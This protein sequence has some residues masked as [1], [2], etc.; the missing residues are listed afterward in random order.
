MERSVIERQLLE[1]PENPFDR[2]SLTIME[3]NEYNQTDFAKM[4]IEDYLS[5]LNEWLHKNIEN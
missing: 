2:S 1:K 3:L 5:K 4:A